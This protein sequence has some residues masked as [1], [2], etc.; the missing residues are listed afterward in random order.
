MATIRTFPASRS[1]HRDPTTAGRVVTLGAQQS[2]FNTGRRQPFYNVQFSPTLTWARGNHTWK[3]GY[4][5]RQLRQTEINE[6]WR[7]GAYAFDGTYTRASSTAVN[8]YGQGIA[9]FLLGIPLNGSFIEL[10]PEQDYN[11]ISHGF[12][13]HDDWRIG[14]KLSLN[15]GLRYDLEL[16]LTEAENRNTRGFDFTT[17]NPI[18][19]QAQAQFAANPPAGVPLTA[20]QFAVLGGYQYVDDSNRGIWDRGHATTSSRASG[21]PTRPLRRSS[22]AAAQGCSSRRSRSTP[23]PAW[24]TR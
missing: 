3:F 21:S 19:A 15:L 6:G 24:A 11:T 23:S 18:Q 2:G 4:D 13:V 14:E 17:P 22:S 12:F 8:Q 20:A 7:G 16:G 10:R 9:S 5:W 1:S